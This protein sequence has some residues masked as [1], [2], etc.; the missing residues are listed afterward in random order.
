MVMCSNLDGVADVLC[1]LIQSEAS[2]GHSLQSPVAR[3][4]RDQA[5]RESV[6]L[7]RQ[8]PGMSFTTA[9]QLVNHFKGRTMAEIVACT[10]ADLDV[11]LPWLPKQKR[12]NLLQYFAR[13]YMADDGF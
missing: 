10:E 13:E 12:R 2:K 4:G 5:T 6:A 8:A 3:P 7:L 9:L 11:A 1:S